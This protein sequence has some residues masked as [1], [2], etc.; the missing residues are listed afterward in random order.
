WAPWRMEFIEKGNSE[1]GCIFCRFPAET[2]DEADQRNLLL[3][4][5][6]HSFAMLNK[7]PYTSGHL[8][9]IPRRHTATFEELPAEDLNDLNALLQKAVVALKST[10][11]PD[12]VNLGMNLGKPAGAGIADHLHWHAVPRWTGDN[13]FM[14]V[15]ADTRVVVEHLQQ[16]WARLRPL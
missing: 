12:G 4:R 14:P 13:N 11:R 5:T 8:L 6:A 15:I 10:Y 1:P 2:G 7:Y 9:I 3:G 16:T